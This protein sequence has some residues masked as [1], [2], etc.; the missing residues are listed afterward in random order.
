MLVARND[1]SLDLDV[2][3][4]QLGEIRAIEVFECIEERRIGD[5]GVFDDLGESLV[6]LARRQR[7]QQ[8]NVRDDKRRLMDRA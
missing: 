8:S 7:L 5:H 1:C 3:P 2:S 6:E 4:D